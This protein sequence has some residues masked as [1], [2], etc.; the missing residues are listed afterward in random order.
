MKKIGVLLVFLVLMSGVAY[1]YSFNDFLINMGNAFFKFFSLT[2][3]VVLDVVSEASSTDAAPEIS[4]PEP[5]TVEA[6]KEEPAEEDTS[7]GIVS[8][9]DSNVEVTG[10]AEDEREIAVP[11]CSDFIDN[12][13]NYLKKGICKDGSGKSEERC[14]SDGR[15][16]LEYRCASDK[17]CSGEWYVCPNGCKDGACLSETAAELKPDLKALSVNNINGKLVLGVKNLGT[18]GTFFKTKLVRD[19]V[20]EISDV[21]YYLDA[22]E[23]VDVELGDEYLGAYSLEL[24]LDEDHD[25]SNNK[26]QGRLVAEAESGG[27]E[28]I[29]GGA[30]TESEDV[31]LEDKP[32]FI[33]KIL[34]FLRNI[35]Y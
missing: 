19:G 32:N 7:G 21:N 24:I 22:G 11:S 28:Q 16:V 20:E 2:G 3:F 4:I 34:E 26:I 12:N 14:S 35:F 18:K 29:T 30:T 10:P 33:E 17:R 1:A 13:V 23:V 9:T 31:G 6:T 25:F 5:P 15:S 8:T 27:E